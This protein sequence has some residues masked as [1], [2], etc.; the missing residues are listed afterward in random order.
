MTSAV[1]SPENLVEFAGDLQKEIDKEIKEEN[2]KE[3]DELA[4]NL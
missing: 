2:K 4:A 1:E 3:M